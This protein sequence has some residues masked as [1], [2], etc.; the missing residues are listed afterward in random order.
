MTCRWGSASLSGN[1]NNLADP[2]AGAADTPFIR[3]TNAHYG[4][5]DAFGNLSINPIFDGL[6]PRTI[7]NILGAQEAGL[8]KA[9]RR[10]HLLHG[11]RPVLRPRP[12]LPR[13]GRQRHDSDRRARQWGAGRRTIRPTS[14]AATVAFYRGRRAAAPQQDVAVRR[15]EPGLR[16][17][18][19]RR[20]VPARGRRQRRSRRPSAPGRSRSVEPRLQPAADVA[21]ADPAPLGEQHCLPLECAAGRLRDLR[22][23]SSRA[24]STAASIDA[25]MLPG[26]VVELHG[27]HARAAAR[28]QPVHQP[29]RPLRGRRRARQRELRPDRRC[30]RSGRATTTSMWTSS[31]PRASRERRKRCSRPPRWSTRPN[32]SGSSSPSSPTS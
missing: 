27:Q 17:Q 32:T 25:S 31:S 19:A 30:T 1:G 7:S 26:M 21:R 18:R 9:Q 29:A 23:R 5:P 4:A 12:R 22:S 16:L 14:P 13:Q 10:Q 6:D 3:L 24:S 28:H 15:P 11:V 20:S 2:D 8:P